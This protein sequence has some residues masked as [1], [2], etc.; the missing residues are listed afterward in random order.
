MAEEAERVTDQSRKRLGFSFRIALA[1]ILL[2][3]L[4]SA[5]SF[6]A[7]GLLPHYSKDSGS[8]YPYLPTYIGYTTNHSDPENRQELK[9]Q[10]SVKY[11]LIEESDWYFAYTQKSF[12]STQKPSAPF[13]E[14][15]FAPEM[16]WL[17]RTDNK[18]WMP[19]VQVGFFRHESTGEAGPESRGWNITYIEPAFKLGEAYIIPRVWVPSVLH[20]F[21]EN[22][23]ATDNPDIYRYLGYGKLTAIVGTRS[24]TQTA[25][26]LQYAPKDRAITWE[27]QAD[28]TWRYLSEVISKVT[29]IKYVPKWNPSYF[30]QARNG[31]GEG[32]KTYNQKTSSVVVGISMV[33]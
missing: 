25:L 29:G 23:S 24:E 13:R 21:N 6:A 22:K 9:F 1:G 11:E 20:E 26:T 19:F 17:Y 12:W 2:L 32:L 18:P 3:V 5:V 27:V 4:L 33:R 14:S 10:V 28:L 7:D 16:F 30:L 31:Y 15:N 8:F